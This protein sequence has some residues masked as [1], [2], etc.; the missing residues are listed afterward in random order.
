[1]LTI[2]DGLK[3]EDEMRILSNMIYELNNVRMLFLNTNLFLFFVKHEFKAY[4]LNY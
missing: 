3:F 1:M 2:R 4:S